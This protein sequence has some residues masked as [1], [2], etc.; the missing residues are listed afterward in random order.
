MTKPS[1]ADL[2]GLPVL[3]HEVSRRVPGEAQG[4]EV[5]EHTGCYSQRFGAGPPATNFSTST[6]PKCKPAS[7]APVSVSPIFPGLTL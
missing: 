7:V 4:Y 5:W 3:V 1:P 6:Q 2:R